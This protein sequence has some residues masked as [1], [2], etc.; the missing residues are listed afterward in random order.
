M[1]IT[2]VQL[3]GVETSFHAQPTNPSLI[4]NTNRTKHKK[5]INGTKYKS[6][7][8]KKSN[9]QT[10]Q[11]TNQTKYKCNKILWNKIHNK[12]EYKED[13]IQDDIT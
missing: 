6:E 4:Q 3:Y 9:V 11:N 12:P 2:F 5:N 8:K 7:K 1:S 13:K 10:E